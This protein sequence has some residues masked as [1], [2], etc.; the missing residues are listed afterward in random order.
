MK[1][2]SILLVI[3]S[4]ISIIILSV[5][6]NNKYLVKEE[7]LATYIDG[8]KTDSFPA[9]GTV[10]FSKADC[11]NNTNIEWDN[12]NWGLYVT[13]LSNKVKC[14]IYFK[15]GEN[16]VTK[17]TSLASSDT[18]NM[19]SD[20]PDNNIRY[21]GAN[22]NNYVYF[23]CDDYNN[24]TSDTCELWRI[25]GVF[26][27]IEKEDG[28]KENLIK[29]VRNDSIGQYS[30]DNK[31]TT[32]GAEIDYGKNDWTTA[33][34]NYLLNPGHESESVGGSL[35][36][37]AKKGNC[38]AG[39]NNATVACDFTKVGLK[40]DKTKNSIE[41]VIWNN[42]GILNSKHTKSDTQQ[43][44]NFERGTE[45]YK[46]NNAYWTGKIAL[47][48]PSDYGYA[49]SGNYETSRANCLSYNL[50][51]L[52]EQNSNCFFNDYLFSKDENQFVLTSKSDISYDVFG[53]KNNGKLH[54]PY[55]RESNY[56][57]RPTLFLKSNISI[58]IG[59]GSSDS[60]YQLS[61]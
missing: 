23:N 33:R 18:T 11:D 24:Q 61:L 35:Y 32:S 34:L 15:T 29:I 16:A 30:W 9:K 38:Y 54:D 2:R 12:D 39:E 14:N 20:D 25:I 43:W 21:I 7:S 55:A 42:G 49:T 27:N 46:N 59:D 53:I 26:N 5:N 36:Y 41:T 50:Y 1:K 17:I 48:Y 52:W 44:Y 3:V 6:S 13:N 22:P 8:K 10:A 28:T 19:T 45:V 57:V 56:G 40:N 37:N 47:I 58:G 4:F 31:D 51:N 60:P